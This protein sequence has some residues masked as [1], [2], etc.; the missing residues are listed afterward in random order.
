MKR[1][2][3]IAAGL[4]LSALLVAAWNESRK[5]RPVVHVPTLSGR[6][7]YCLTCHADVPQISAAHPTGTVGCVSCHGGQP[8]ALDADLAHSTMRGGRNP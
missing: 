6:P 5:P 4:L 1:A 8:L 3:L 2:T 7:E